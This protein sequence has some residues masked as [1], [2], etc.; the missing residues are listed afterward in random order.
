MTDNDK[1]L[2]RTRLSRLTP[3]GLVD[4]TV[5]VLKQAR[6]IGGE[7]VLPGGPMYVELCRQAMIAA[8]LEDTF[9]SLANLIQGGEFYDDL[10]RCRRCGW[11]KGYHR[12]SDLRCPDIKPIMGRIRMTGIMWAQ[13][14]FEATR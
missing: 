3:A 14:V 9:L 6:L 2:Y 10:A 11:K 8:G 12:E 13:T 7:S 5:I 1:A 4:E